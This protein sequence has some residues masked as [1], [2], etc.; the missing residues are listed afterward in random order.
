MRV[1]VRPKA[2]RR[3]F[4]LLKSPAQKNADAF[5]EIL[6]VMAW[7]EDAAKA[8]RKALKS[9]ERAGRPTVPILDEKGNFKARWRRMTKE[10]R[11]AWGYGGRVLE[12]PAKKKPKK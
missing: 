3:S 10:Q 4:P 11:A 6:A 1:S 9:Y 12:L 2:L 7:D 8:Y 5:S